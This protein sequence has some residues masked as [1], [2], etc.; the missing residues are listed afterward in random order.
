MDIF[1]ANTL[2]LHSKCRRTQLKL[3]P[4]TSVKL[5]RPRGRRPIFMRCFSRWTSSSAE[6]RCR[7]FSSSSGISVLHTPWPL[8]LPRAQPPSYESPVDA[9]TALAVARVVGELALVRVAVLEDLAAVAG[10]LIVVPL[11]LVAAAVGGL[12]HA[13]AVA[14][15]LEELAVVR[16]AVAVD[17]HALA[18][19]RA[20]VEAA[21]V[22][23]AVR[24]DEQPTPLAEVALP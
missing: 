1:S 13:P 6:T 14:A 24:R 9:T 2:S 23:R 16:A 15:E 5:G 10:A 17:H 18:R 8:R 11:A 3:T 22:H 19:R 20:A 12:H 4:R 7:S 21:V